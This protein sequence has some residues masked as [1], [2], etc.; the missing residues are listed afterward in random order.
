MIY[1]KWLLYFTLLER[2]WR[3]VLDWLWEMLAN[4]EIQSW[5]LRLFR[6]L[7]SFQQQADFF[8]VHF[9]QKYKSNEKCLEHAHLSINGLL[10]LQIR[11]PIKFDSWIKLKRRRRRGR[12]RFCHIHLKQN[13]HGND[14]EKEKRS[15][16]E[17]EMFSSPRSNRLHSLLRYQNYIHFFFLCTLKSN[18][19]R[20]DKTWRR[21]KMKFE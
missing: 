5:N 6:H 7:H 12:K 17:K 15:R 3:S 21:T 19:I 9:S 14:G 18:N 10:S 11:V 16:N 20:R 8:S 2:N 1:D 4:E 13:K